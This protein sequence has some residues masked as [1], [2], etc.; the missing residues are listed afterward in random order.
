MTSEPTLAHSGPPH[1]AKALKWFLRRLTDV[2]ILAAI[3]GLAFGISRFRAHD[4][5]LEHHQDVLTYGT[6]VSKPTA[7]RLLDTLVELRIFS[8]TEAHAY[9]NFVAAGQAN[10]PQGHNYQ[11]SAVAPTFDY[12]HFEVRFA[13]DKNLL[14]PP[15]GAT[16]RERTTA[17]T[18]RAQAIQQCR[19]L[20]ST[21]FDNR[22]LVVLMGDKYLQVTGVLCELP[23]G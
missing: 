5:F 11:E 6:G 10:K 9:V 12:D 18:I 15:D 16:P 1:D 7:H 23:A 19:H 22:P 8:G 13:I 14:F 20:Q 3:V 2:A 17:E 21:V 4:R